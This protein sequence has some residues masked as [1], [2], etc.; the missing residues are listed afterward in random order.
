MT[1]DLPSWPTLLKPYRWWIAGGVALTALAG[2]AGWLVRKVAR[3][4]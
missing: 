2:A 1:R 4:S 3:K